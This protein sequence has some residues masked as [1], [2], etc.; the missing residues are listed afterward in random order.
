[1]EQKVVR[2]IHGDNGGIDIGSKKIGILG[3]SDDLNLV[4]DDGE[5]VTQ[6]TT[7]LINE[8]KTIGLNSN[9]NNTLKP[10]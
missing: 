6:S 9:Y 7:A 10:K 3:F 8:A 5:S 1:M 4:G 2:S